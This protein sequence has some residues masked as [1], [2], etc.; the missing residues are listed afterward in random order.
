MNDID[1]QIDHMDSYQKRLKRKN[2]MKI[3]TNVTTAWV[4]GLVSILLIVLD[5]YMWWNAIPGDT[6]SEVSLINSLRHPMIPFVLG[7]I[8]G[9]LF[10]P[11]V[12]S[13]DNDS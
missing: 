5:V 10:W 8:M 4:I 7:V 12:V 3:K 1:E 9:H 2:H 6:I 11:Q 13:N